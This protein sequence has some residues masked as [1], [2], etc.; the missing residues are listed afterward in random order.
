MALSLNLSLSARKNIIKWLENLRN[1][2]VGIKQSAI[3]FFDQGNNYKS[4]ARKELFNNIGELIIDAI[5]NSGQSIALTPTGRYAISASK[6]KKVKPEHFND[7]LKEWAIDENLDKI[8]FSDPFTVGKLTQ[9]DKEG[10]LENFDHI[11]I[12]EK[13]GKFR[14]IPAMEWLIKKY[15]ADNYPWDSMNKDSNFTG[16]IVQS[17]LYDDVDEKIINEKVLDLYMK[18]AIMRPS[19]I[20]ERPTIPPAWIIAKNNDSIIKKLVPYL[21]FSKDVIEDSVISE[22]RAFFPEKKDIF[23]NNIAFTDD[24][25]EKLA[26]GLINSVDNRGVDIW[27]NLIIALMEKSNKFTEV[28]SKE[29]DWKYYEDVLKLL[30]EVRAIFIF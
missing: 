10:K 18:Y 12:F 29:T 1:D 22:L 26:R 23:L 4:V 24:E 21:G 27:E 13:F 11:K 15:G 30:P 14:N 7:K 9:L 5:R 20:A 3:S 28:L 2:G 25:W 8:S 19:N 6:L 16:N 17:I